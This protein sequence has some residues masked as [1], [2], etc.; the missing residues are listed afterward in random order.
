MGQN[1]ASTSASIVINNAYTFFDNNNTVVPGIGGPPSGFSQSNF[2][3][4]SFDFGLPF[5]Y[6]RNIYT[7]IEN[8]T[9]GGINGPYFAY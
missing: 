6:G 8:T 3:P 2:Y 7:A 1:G 4:N 5:F 9:A